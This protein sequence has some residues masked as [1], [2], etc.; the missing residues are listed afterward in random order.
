[1]YIDKT[2]SLLFSIIVDDK[3]KEEEQFQSEINTLKES[4]L[5][6]VRKFNQFVI[7]LR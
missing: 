1:M 4:N 5:E 2:K 7:E 6:L 3:I